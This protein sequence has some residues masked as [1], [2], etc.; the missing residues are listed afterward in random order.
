MNHKKI[1]VCKHCHR[2]HLCD[3]KAYGTSN[4]LAHSKVC[5]QKPAKMLKDPR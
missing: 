2:R 4:M 5:L 3:S 1:V